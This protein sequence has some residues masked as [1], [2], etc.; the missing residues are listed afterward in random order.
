MASRHLEAWHLSDSQTGTNRANRHLS[1]NFKP[2]CGEIEKLEITTMECAESV[3]QVSEVGV[4]KRVHQV[5]Q[6]TI[7]K[8]PH[9]GDVQRVAAAHETTT[10]DEVIAV[11]Q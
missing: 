10:L 6:R 7:S 11:Q 9:T 3:T 5:Q 4:I 1:L 8:S 2:W